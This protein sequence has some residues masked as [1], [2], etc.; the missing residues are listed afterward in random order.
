M[1]IRYEHTEAVHT[2]PQRA[3]AAI[4]NLPLTARWLPPCVSLEKI[5]EGPNAVGDKLRYVYKQGGKISEMAGE[6]VARTPDERLHTRYFDTMFEVSVELRVAPS[7]EGTLTTHIIEIKPKKLMA[8]LF[9]PLVRLGI[10]KQ[11]RQA[12]ANLKKLLEESVP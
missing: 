11:T 9:S 3:F 6:I 1:P 12:A 8:K 2:T 10:G 7:A 5:G 4:D